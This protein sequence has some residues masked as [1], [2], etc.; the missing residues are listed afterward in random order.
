M[1]RKTLFDF[2]IKS[3]ESKLSPV[4]S[5]TTVSDEQIQQKPNFVCSENEAESATADLKAT[6]APDDIGEVD[7]K[8]VPSTTVSE[9][10]LTEAV[11]EA[12]S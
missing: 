1:K 7:G 8:P 12:L 11:W 5:A 9:S 10:L 6:E 3:K 2:G 4:E